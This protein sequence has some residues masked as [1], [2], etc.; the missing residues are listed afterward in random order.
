MFYC[1]L[2]TSWVQ[3]QILSLKVKKKKK[4]MIHINRSNCHLCCDPT[5]LKLMNLIKNAALVG[6]FPSG[7]S[8]TSAAQ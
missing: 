2:A 4:I 8:E 3:L 5:V 7:I 1:M 6:S